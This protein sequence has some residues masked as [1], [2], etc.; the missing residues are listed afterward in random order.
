MLWRK[1][2]Q[3][4]KST[5]CHTVWHV[6]K[7]HY[8]KSLIYK[9]SEILCRRSSGS[10]NSSGSSGISLQKLS[11]PGFWEVYQFLSGRSSW[12]TSVW[13]GSLWTGIFRSLH[14][15]SVGFKSWLWLGLSRT[16]RDVSQSQSCIVSTVCVKSSSSRK[17][18]RGPSLRSCALW[19]LFSP[20][21][22]LFLAA[23]ILQSILTSLPGSASSHTTLI[24]VNIEACIFIQTSFIQKKM[25]QLIILLNPV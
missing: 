11:T 17:V 3:N 16:V 22:S 10:T 19:S 15:R 6:Y 4:V 18:I 5:Q 7:Y 13:M 2:L 8:L 21:T 20:R 25:L 9:S 24:N 14:R 1:T 12:T 23:F